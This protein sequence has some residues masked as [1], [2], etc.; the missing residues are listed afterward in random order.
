MPLGGQHIVPRCVCP[1]HPLFPVLT[2]GQICTIHV[3]D[4]F[5]PQRA[6]L[7]S[8]LRVTAIPS[9]TALHS[10]YNITTWI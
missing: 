8:P 3:R 5:R 2:I 4:I 1:Y 6:A 7:P 9:I 10:L